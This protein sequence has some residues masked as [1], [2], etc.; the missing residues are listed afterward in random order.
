MK[1]IVVIGGG[2]SGLIASYVLSR[3]PDVEVVIYEETKIGGEFLAG[4]L[5]Y[6]HYTE[7]MR[8]LMAELDLLHSNYNINGGIHLNECVLPYP[9]CF[10]L[11]TRERVERIQ[12]DHWR[13]TRRAEP[14]PDAKKAMNDPM[15][16][17][18]RQALR[19]DFYDFVKAL[20]SRARVLKG[21]ATALTEK[22]VTIHGKEV[23]FDFCVVT[24][25]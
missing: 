2:V 15:S 18:P 4:G 14:G 11:M 8:Q 7:P 1:K 9:N 25:P 16:A 3:R 12:S 20:A 23:P 19:C 13:K 24:A 10:A 21:S 5:K 17:K 22:T 6:I